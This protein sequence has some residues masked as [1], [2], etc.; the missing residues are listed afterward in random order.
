MKLRKSW[1]NFLLGFNKHVNLFKL[2]NFLRGKYLELRGVEGNTRKCA[3]PV[4][5]F[6]KGLL[7]EQ[8]KK[9]Y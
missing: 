1:K 4:L 5:A 8:L 2:R 9:E 7:R 6:P 3:Y